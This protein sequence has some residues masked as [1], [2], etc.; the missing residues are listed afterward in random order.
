M[1]K[2]QRRTAINKARID[3]LK[4]QQSAVSDSIKSMTSLIDDINGTIYDM[5]VKSDALTLSRRRAAEFEVQTALNN[6]R[7]GRGAG[8]ISGALS[9]LRQD[10]SVLFNS[11]AELAYSTA[12]TQNKLAELAKITGETVSDSQKQLD[13]LN[14]QLTN[15]ESF[16]YT[17]SAQYDEMIKLAQGQY[18]A[19]IACA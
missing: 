1:Q 15:A 9:T 16:T 5:A 4:E 3:S 8:D 11:A 6:A 19:D 13:I 14:A 17:A 2:K 10:P 18:D 7:A 12:V